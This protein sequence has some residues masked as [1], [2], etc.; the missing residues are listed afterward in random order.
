MLVD[1]NHVSTSY[2]DQQKYIYIFL[3]GRY[4]HVSTS[5]KSYNCIVY[6]Q[7]EMS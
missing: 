1:I 5:Y 7:V 2:K 6:V 3:F 4:N